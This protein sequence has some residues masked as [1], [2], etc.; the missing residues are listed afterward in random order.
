[1]AAAG[2][3]VDEYI[4]GGFALG[5]RGR[6]VMGPA[7]IGGGGLETGFRSMKDPWLLGGG[8]GGDV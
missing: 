2:L 4:G 6:W 8:S 7:G 5:A 1:M 3:G